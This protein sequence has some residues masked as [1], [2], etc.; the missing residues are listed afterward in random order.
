M[1]IKSKSKLK[2]P[3]EFSQEDITKRMLAQ[4]LFIKPTDIL[5]DQERFYMSNEELYYLSISIKSFDSPKLQRALIDMVHLQCDRD[6]II[7]F[8]K[9]LPK[10]FKNKVMFSC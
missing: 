3:S 4:S 8:M 1:K 7:R 10:E 9:L 6:S 5:M 2:P